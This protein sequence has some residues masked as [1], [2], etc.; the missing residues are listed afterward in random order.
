MLTKCIN[1]KNKLDVTKSNLHVTDKQDNIGNKKCNNVNKKLRKRE[2]R[3]IRKNEKGDISITLNLT[4]AEPFG[5]DYDNA[6]LTEVYAQVK[7]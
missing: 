3:I 5:Y 7:Y 1:N 2:E 6:S 4:D